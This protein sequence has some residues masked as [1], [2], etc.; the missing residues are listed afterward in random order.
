M[1]KKI[2]LLIL[3]MAL[4]VAA[5]SNT[6]KLTILVNPQD[7]G[8]VTG[9][10]TYA[11]DSSIE[12]TAS[13]LAN[14]V[15]SNWTDTTGS[16]LSY[17]PEF[18]LTM[19]MNDLTIVANFIPAVYPYGIIDDFESGVNLWWKP[20]GSGSTT[21]VVEGTVENPSSYI[22]EDTTIVNPSTNSTIS[23]KLGIKWDTTIEWDETV[24]H[25]P[26]HFVRQHIPNANSNVSGRRFQWGQQLESYV[27]GDGSNSRIR[28]MARDSLHQLEGSEW[29]TID[30][31][32]WRRL[33]WDYN[34]DK[35]VFG[36]I[37]GNGTMD[38]KD[39]EPS[40]YFDSFQITRDT[41][42]LVESTLLYIDDV[43]FFTPSWTTHKLT[44]NIAN[45][46][47]EEIV[48]I[49]DFNYPKGAT[50]MTLF[51]GEYSYQ[52]I[53]DDYSASGSFMLDKD[54]VIDVT[55]QKIPVYFDLILTSSNAEW[56][57]VTGAGEYE[58]GDEVE[59]HATVF[60]DNY[61]FLYW[62]LGDTIFSTNPTLV[63][64]MPGEDLTFSA[65]FEQLFE[66]TLTSNINAAGT[67]AGGGKY[68]SGQSVNLTATPGT[69]YEFMKWTDVSGAQDISLEQKITYIMPEAN[70]T[71]IAHFKITTDIGDLESHSITIFPNPLKDKINIR[72]N[73]A[74][75]Q[76]E[77]VDLNGRIVFEKHFDG[78]KEFVIESHLPAG[79]YFMKILTG[80]NA[81]VKK[82]MVND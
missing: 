49:G 66:L 57:Q 82:I 77:I 58:E 62:M 6:Y 29:I 7:V 67:L 46:S 64:N 11:P 76:V 59:I 78:Q 12:L 2:H 26:T 56:G 21:G 40:Y 71:L 45:V 80:K 54:M 74:I 52:I 20:T 63:F 41:M 51:E 43:R 28:F 53:R 48:S 13:H 10:G 68:Q 31:T 47:G 70:V 60:N 9:S 3:C 34:D 18:T 36:W 25:I 8:I 44:F 79:I 35:N 22:V 32:G 14:A 30:W 23:M 15:F 19:P 65:I 55:L 5:Q 73:S 38:G 69:E 16:I 72:S 50:K 24:G 39:G 37:T 4:S 75:N 17:D 1:M 33:V 42:G 27:Y 81:T 61:L